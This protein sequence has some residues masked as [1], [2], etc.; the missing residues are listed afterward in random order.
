LPADQLQALDQARLDL[1]LS[2]SEFSRR[3]IDAYLRQLQ[4]TAK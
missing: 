2:R 4:A 1:R 3:A